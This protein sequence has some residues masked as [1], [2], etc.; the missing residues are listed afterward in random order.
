MRTF[1]ITGADSRLKTGPT[2][3]PVEGITKWWSGIRQSWLYGKD[4][5]C[6]SELSCL[7]QGIYLP[8]HQFII[9]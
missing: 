7:G 8:E 1:E 3:L 2:S 5:P 9:S 4:L 6:T